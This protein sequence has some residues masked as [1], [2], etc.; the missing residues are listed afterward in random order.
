MV[1]L[2]SLAAPDLTKRSPRSP[3]DIKAWFDLLDLDD[4]VTFGGKP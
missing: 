3:R 1:N 2:D 4:Y